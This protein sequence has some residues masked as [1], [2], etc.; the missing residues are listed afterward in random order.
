MAATGV[1]VSGREVL[2][3]FVV[4]LVIIVIDEGG[5]LRFKSAG[6]EVI[7]QQDAVL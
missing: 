6:Q 5:N 4:T 2:Q 7:F 3:T 1:D